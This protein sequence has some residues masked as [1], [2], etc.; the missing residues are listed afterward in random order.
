[1]RPT[2]MEQP[3]LATPH[4]KSFMEDVSCLPVRRRS[5]PSPYAAM[6]TCE[7]GGGRVLGHRTDFLPLML[8]AGAMMHSNPGDMVPDVEPAQHLTTERQHSSHTPLPHKDSCAFCGPRH[9]P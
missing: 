9:V 5:L 6:C 3:R 2:R 1:M 7:E 4:E 8:A